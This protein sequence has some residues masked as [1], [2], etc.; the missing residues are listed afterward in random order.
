MRNYLKVRSDGSG[1][2]VER[3]GVLGVMEVG[4]VLILT[5]PSEVLAHDDKL[6]YH[7]DVKDK[8]VTDQSYMKVLRGSHARLHYSVSL[9]E[10]SFVPHPV[11]VYN[12]GNLIMESH[13]TVRG[14]ARIVEAFLL[15]RKGSGEKFLKGNVRALTTVRN[16]ERTLIYDVF[17][18]EDSDY[19]DPNV[20]GKEGLITVY[21]IDGQSY[22]FTRLPLDQSKADS[23]WRSLSGIEF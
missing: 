3:S 16:E 21:E 6:V 13:F 17:R 7:I 10:S 4:D 8:M 2:I 12:G 20:M 5:N 15:G 18:V 11:I 9:K 14:R 19:M 1:T 23:I 22:D